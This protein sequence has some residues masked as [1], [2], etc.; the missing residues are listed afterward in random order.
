MRSR[1][2]V[3]ATTLAFAL[4]GSVWVIGHETVSVSV[5]KRS[6]DV[7][8]CSDLDITFDGEPALRDEETLRQIR[9]SIQNGAVS[10]SG[11]PNILGKRLPIARAWGGTDSRACFDGQRSCAGSLGTMTPL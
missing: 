9:E 4:L 2:T 7:R 3:A 6:D 5:S 8:R 11:V 10:S 1:R